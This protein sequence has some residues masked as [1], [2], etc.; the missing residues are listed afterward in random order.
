MESRHYS[1]LGALGIIFVLSA[2]LWPAYSAKPPEWKGDEHPYNCASAEEFS[3]THDFLKS[4]EL[5]EV[6]GQEMRKIASEVSRHCTGASEKF[7][8]VFEV[9]MKSGVSVQVSTQMGL[10]YAAREIAEANVFVEAFKHL[11][12]EK[13]LDVDFKT[14]T[15]VAEELAESW[16]GSEG[17]VG[18]DFTEM[19]KFCLDPK[20]LNLS[21][22][23]CFELSLKVAQL[24]RY[25]PEG[26]HEPF[27]K[28]YTELR[29]NKKF[30]LPVRSALEISLQVLAEGPKGPKNFID[31]Y[32][33]AIS[34]K[35]LSETPAFALK[36]AL[37]LSK[38]SHRGEAPPQVNE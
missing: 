11:Y 36:H 32:D 8:V 15:R 9:L 34:D 2:P 38:Y 30:G 18:K 7:R 29:E 1:L 21:Q 13:F 23:E 33:Y 22:K 31:A 27:Q 5:A 19:V 28:L 14:S 20:S 12:L 25:F 10:K 37:K 17:R 24:S 16:H 6:G 35:G 3:A 26:S 4:Q